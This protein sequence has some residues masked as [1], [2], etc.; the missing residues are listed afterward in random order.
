MDI[1]EV[2]ENTAMDALSGEPAL[3]SQNTCIPLHSGKLENEPDNL[4]QG[5]SFKKKLLCLLCALFLLAASMAV[6]VYIS[7][8]HVEGYAPDCACEPGTFVYF[9][10]YAQNSDKPEPIEWMVLENN[11]E[12]ALLFAVYAVECLPFNDELADISWEQCAL[13]RW[14]GDVF[15]YKAFSEEER[16]LIVN[17]VNPNI[18]LIFPSEVECVSN[19]IVPKTVTLTPNRVSLE[20]MDDSTHDKVFCLSESEIHK[21]FITDESRAVK[22]PKRM[23]NARNYRGFSWY[24]LRT[25]GAHDKKAVSVRSNGTVNTN[26]SFVNVSDIVVRPALRIKLKKS[27]G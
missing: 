18:K 22:I 9:G 15:Y 8:H 21:Y 14:L 19:D 7:Q 4:V 27:T 25:R 20:K 23:S 10:N 5:S 24:W 17:S 13:R 26:G 16:A 6:Y 2:D 11:G 1:S 12:N 3:A